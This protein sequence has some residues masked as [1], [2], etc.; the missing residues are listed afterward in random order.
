MNAHA[1]QLYANRP[2]EDQVYAAGVEAFSMA[3]TSAATSGILERFVN[4]F[5]GLTTGILNRENL[6]NIFPQ[7]APVSVHLDLSRSQTKFMT[8]ANDVGYVK[9]ADI[10][11]PSINGLKRPLLEYASVLADHIDLPTKALEVLKQAKKLI[12][13]I[14]NNSDLLYSASTTSRLSQV[15][16]LVK[17]RAMWN[18][19]ISDCIGPDNHGDKMAY[20]RLVTNN[21]QMAGVFDARNRLKDIVSSRTIDEV[22]DEI[23][24]LKMHMN[25]V[26]VVIGSDDES[27][28][29]NAQ[30]VAKLSE[31]LFQCATMVQDVGVY[32]HRVNSFTQVVDAIAATDV[33]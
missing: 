4:V 3:A 18:K 17:Y 24:M 2:L 7:A 13:E 32:L 29:P 19:A 6:K 21:G 16:P 5:D 11:V 25:D 15:D 33:S 14:A 31:L 9:V 12:A 26:A 8:A 20:G 28:K 27:K 10:M 1:S 30:V 23:W 22:T